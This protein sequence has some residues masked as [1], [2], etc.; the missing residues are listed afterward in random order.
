MLESSMPGLLLST[1]NDIQMVT[2][3]SKYHFSSRVRNDTNTTGMYQSLTRVRNNTN[4]LP[5]EAVKINPRL[6][7]EIMDNTQTSLE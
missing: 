6:E 4:Y 1:R 5:L 7:R 3:A 2:Q